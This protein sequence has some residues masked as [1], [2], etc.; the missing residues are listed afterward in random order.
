MHNIY[1]SSINKSSSPDGARYLL[2]KK[3]LRR[4]ATMEKE[5]DIKLLK[6]WEDIDPHTLSDED[7]Q[8][9]FRAMESETIFTFEGVP[10]SIWITEEVNSDGSINITADARPVWNKLSSEF[11]TDELAYYLTKF[12]LSIEDGVIVDMNGNKFSHIN[13]I[14]NMWY[15]ILLLQR[16][17][18]FHNSNLKP[19]I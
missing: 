9:M 13:K 4:L 19:R 2:S 6:N 12:N 18:Q 11:T 7:I 10:Y 8:N 17:A 14:T 15:F 3:L 5:G 1:L 16:V